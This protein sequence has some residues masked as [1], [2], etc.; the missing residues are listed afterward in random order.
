MDVLTWLPALKAYQS[1]VSKID[2]NH[3][4]WSDRLWSDCCSSWLSQK[5]FPGKTAV[6]TISAV[7]WPRHFWSLSWARVSATVL[8]SHAWRST[9]GKCWGVVTWPILSANFY[10]PYPSLWQHRRCI[11]QL[12]DGPLPW[13][14]LPLVSYLELYQLHFSSPDKS[15][16]LHLRIAW[17][18]FEQKNRV[19]RYGKWKMCYRGAWY[20]SVIIP[21]NWTRGKQA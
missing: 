13:S 2:L 15:F 14:T 16:R 20:K 19:A 17:I 12:C 11:Y 3:R 9:E 1:K 8:C 4:L 18:E 6:S 21:V 7:T 10:N 5:L